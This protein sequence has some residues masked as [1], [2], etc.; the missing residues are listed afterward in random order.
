MANNPSKVKL[1]LAAGLRRAITRLGRR[2]RAER[3]AN[4]LSA[5][6]LG[7]LSYLFRIKE[8]SP[9][10]IAKAERLQPQSLSKLLAELEAEKLTS[11]IKD[12]RDG[13]Q[14]ILKITQ[15]GRD[16]LLRDM[17]ERDAWLA[18]AIACLSETELE[19]LRISAPIIEYLA[20]FRGG[21]DENGAPVNETT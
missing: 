8:C 5:T 11:R 21:F 14:S 10:A 18:S 6:K 3:S 1:D 9:G 17:Q 16:A 12:R 2:L 7:V 15:K 13:R 4:A 19:V 20:D